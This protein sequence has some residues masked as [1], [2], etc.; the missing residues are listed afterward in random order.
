MFEIDIVFVK[1]TKINTKT[2]FFLLLFPC[3]FCYRLFLSCRRCKSK[4]QRCYHPY[5]N[6]NSKRQPGY[7]LCSHAAGDKGLRISF[8][9]S[10]T[11][12]VSWNSHV[13]DGGLQH[14]ADVQMC[15]LPSCACHQSIGNQMNI[16]STLNVFRLALVNNQY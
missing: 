5:A 12:A 13:L 11:I 16:I 3:L 7:Y 10:Q 2:F 1:M 14:K 4:L 6:E 15:N 9:S 8:V